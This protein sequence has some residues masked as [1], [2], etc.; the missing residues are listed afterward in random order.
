MC[1][2]PA[3]RGRAVAYSTDVQRQAMFVP[4]STSPSAHSNYAKPFARSARILV[5]RRA[6]GIEHL[7]LSQIAESG[8]GWAWFRLEPTTSTV[9]VAGA[10][11][12][13]SPD[14]S[15][16]R[17]QG[18][19]ARRLVSHR[20]EVIG[21]AVNARSGRSQSARAG[22]AA[23]RGDA[24]RGALRRRCARRRDRRLR[25][26]PAGAG[27]ASSLANACASSPAQGQSR[28]RRRRA[29]R[30]WKTRRPATCKRRWRSRL[31]SAV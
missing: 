21:T 30:P 26:Q 29:R 5:S 20:C 14:H 12:R 3:E 8:H 16:T 19:S 2:P 6:V 28:W 10:C 31:G 24:S 1:R 22:G 27:S 17:E 11:A 4:I 7:K 9:T 13:A 25:C 23:V 15:V 18:A